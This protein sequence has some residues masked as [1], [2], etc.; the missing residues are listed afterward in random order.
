MEMSQSQMGGYIPSE[1]ASMKCRLVPLESSC[2]GDGVRGVSWG[3][4]ERREG[5]E[6]GEYLVAWAGSG[7]RY[8]DAYC[9]GVIGPGDD[10]P[11]EWE[12]VGDGVRVFA[13]ERSASAQ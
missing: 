9:G 13:R 10:A 2:T 12:N 7:W 4:A 3:D 6:E 1:A 11:D 8:W 5:D